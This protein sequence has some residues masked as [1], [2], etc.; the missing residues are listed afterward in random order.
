MKALQQCEDTEG[1]YICWDDDTIQT[2]F[3][4]V[5]YIYIYIYNHIGSSKSSYSAAHIPNPLWGALALAKK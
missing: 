3:K 4:P 2:T 5:L 1:S